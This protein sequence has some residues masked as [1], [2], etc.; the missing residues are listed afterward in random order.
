MKKSTVVW[1]LCLTASIALL[2]GCGKKEEEPEVVE[3][4][5]VAEVVVQ[6][7]ADATPVYTGPVSYLTGL[8]IDEIVPLP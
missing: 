4:T 2:A 8:P 3:E 6:E 7:S 5:P 1:V